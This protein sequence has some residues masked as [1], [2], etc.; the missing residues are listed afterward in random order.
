[1]S[2]SPQPPPD[3]PPFRLV[4]FGAGATTDFPAATAQDRG[5]LQSIIDSIKIEPPP[6]TPSAS[7]TGSQ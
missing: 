2:R 4:A 6:P 7:P 1:M 3:W 5:E